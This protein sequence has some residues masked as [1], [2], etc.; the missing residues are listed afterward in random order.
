MITRLVPARRAA[1]PIWMVRP[2]RYPALA[3]ARDRR[4]CSGIPSCTAAAHL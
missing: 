4:F 1:P 3:A 2:R